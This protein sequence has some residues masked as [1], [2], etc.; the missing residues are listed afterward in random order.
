[1]RKDRAAAEGPQSGHFDDV[2]ARNIP[3]C[4]GHLTRLGSPERRLFIGSQQVLALHSSFAMLLAERTR[5]GLDL[6]AGDHVIAEIVGHEPGPLFIAVGGLHGNEPAG[7]IAARRVAARLDATNVAG[8]IAFLAGNTRALALGTRYLGTDLNRHFTPHVIDRI[9]ALRRPSPPTSEDD[10][11]AELLS[12]FDPLIASARG[13]VFVVDMHTTSADGRPFATLGDTLRN[14]AFATNVPARIVLG[15][16][17]QLD[18][19]MLEHLSNLGCITLGFEAGQHTSPSSVD[20]HEA[21]LWI[22]LSAAGVVRR[23]GIPDFDDK[24]AAVWG[25][26]PRRYGMTA[27]RRYG[28]AA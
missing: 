16:E 1:M 24:V 7:V 10:E 11:V 26:E 14:R 13:D 6:S 18:G 2:I 9:E 15:I 25:G 20:R 12:M 28:R 23:E 17:E 19:T 3:Q 8:T 27:S 21:L 5:N 4:V 22:T